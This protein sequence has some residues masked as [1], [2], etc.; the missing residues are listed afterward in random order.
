MTIAVEPYFLGFQQPAHR[1]RALSIDTARSGHLSSEISRFIHRKKFHLAQ[2]R[3][4]DTR[5]VQTPPP[6]RS[7]LDYGVAGNFE[8]GLLD[9]SH[10]HRKIAGQADLHLSSTPKVDRANP[11]GKNWHIV[12]KCGSGTTFFWGIESR[13]PRYISWMSRGTRQTWN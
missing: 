6:R 7:G 3:A 12:G 9:Q 11:L 5:C 10:Q 13:Y 8:L 4:I 1:V 2:R